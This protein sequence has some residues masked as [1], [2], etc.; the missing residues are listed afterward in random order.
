MRNAFVHA[1]AAPPEAVDVNGHANNLEY[2]RW[3]QDAATG[4]TAA[5]GW[6]ERYLETRT[7]WVIRSHLIEYLRPAF[8]GEALA[9]LTWIAGFGVGLSPRRYLFWR[10]RSPGDRSG[11]NHLGFRRCGEGPPPPHP[12]RI[13]GGRR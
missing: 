11:R 7:T 1:F 6:P 2:L 10:A 9:V 12:G 5:Q 4:H 13:P 8:A 3:M